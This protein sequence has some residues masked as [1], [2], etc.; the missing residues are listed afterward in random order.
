MKRRAIVH[1][2]P[3]SGP[4]DASALVAGIEAGRMP[5]AVPRT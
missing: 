1:R 2:L 3:M 4:D 5:T